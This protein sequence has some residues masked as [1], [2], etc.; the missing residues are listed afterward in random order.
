MKYYS[1]M[2]EERKP[3]ERLLDAAAALLASEGSTVSTRAIC[4]AAG[5]TAPTLYHYFGDRDGLLTAVV[6]HGFATYLDGKR[7]LE[8]T[9]D[10]L[11]DLRLGWDNHIAWGVANPNFYALMY[12]QVRPGQHAAAA[13]EAEALLGKKL[14][15]AARAG[16]L[17]VPIETGVRMIMA[18]NT[19]LTLQLI[20]AGTTPDAVDGDL[21]RRVRDALFDAILAPGEDAVSAARP[22]A[23]AAITLKAALAGEAGALAPA[24]SA[25]LDVWLDRIASAR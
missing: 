18:G 5:V 19:G 8:S 14:A 13:D 12:G 2:E 24:E 21:V 7:L 6:S 11:E 9:N 3:R 15:A 22:A 10:P 23:A 25:L 4:E 17:R 20:A 1:D 16:M